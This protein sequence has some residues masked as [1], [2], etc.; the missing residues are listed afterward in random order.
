LK[1]I[2]KEK[3]IVTIMNEV[4]YFGTPFGNLVPEFKNENIN[5]A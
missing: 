5:M 3:P 4:K 2:L 1:D